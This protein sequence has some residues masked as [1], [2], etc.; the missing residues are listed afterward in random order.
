VRIGN[1][2]GV[3][4]GAGEM[5]AARAVPEPSTLLAMAAGLLLPMSFRLRS[6]LAPAA[7]R[8]LPRELASPPLAAAGRCAMK[9]RTLLCVAFACWG[10]AS[11]VVAQPVP[12][13]SEFEPA[14]G[15][16]RLVVVVSGQTGPHNY[17]SVARNLAAHG[18][19]AVLVDGNDMFVKGGGGEERLQQVIERGLQSPHASP[20]KAAVVGFS[21]GGGATISYATRMPALVSAAVASYP[22]T[23]H[24]KNTK[25]FVMRVEVPLLIMAGT[26]DTYHDCC[27]I[28]TA[29]AIAREASA[30]GKGSLIQL[31]EYPADHGWNIESS[32]AYR[33]AVA[34]D[35]LK[36]TLEFL[37]AHP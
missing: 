28:E 8:W 30:A 29:R 14:S 34:E 37:Q 32:K 3:L 17:T 10:S 4:S 23:R 26:Q 25:G 2:K 11:A 35:G 20:G 5:V 7:H 31:V 15:K 6:R 19:Y 22:L 27:V 1:V 12:A 18:Y 16:G 33:P 21:L 36:R 13:Q 9:I 24:I